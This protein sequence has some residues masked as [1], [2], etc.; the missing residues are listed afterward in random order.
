MLLW[1]HDTRCEAKLIS[2][3]FLILGDDLSMRDFLSSM[4]FPWLLMNFQSSMTFHD[5]SRKF[6]FSMFSRLSRPCGNPDKIMQ[7]CNSLGSLV[8]EISAFQYEACHGFRAGASVHKLFVGG[9]YGWKDITKY[10]R[11]YY[12]LVSLWCRIYA[13]VNW[14][15][16]G[17]DNGLSP[18]RRQTIIWTNVGM[19]LIGPLGIN[20]SDI[21]F[22]INPFSLK[23]KCI[24]KCRLQHGSHFVQGEMS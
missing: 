10:F 22:E 24:W 19:L 6:Y 18:V 8:L 17:S 16:N 14:V 1:I 20:F 3:K 15:S 23:K 11:G 7:N 13:S 5:F 12:S 2:A 9:V 21:L 4:T